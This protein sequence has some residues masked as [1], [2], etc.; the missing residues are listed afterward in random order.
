MVR[1]QI[2]SQTADSSW[3]RK[4]ALQFSYYCQVD[5][6][7][8]RALLPPGQNLPFR[9]AKTIIYSGGMGHGNSKLCGEAF[10][11][12]WPHHRPPGKSLHDPAPVVSVA[13]PT[14]GT[15]FSAIFRNPT[16]RASAATSSSKSPRYPVFR[17]HPPGH[18]LGCVLVW[19]SFLT[20]R[21]HVG[22]IGRKLGRATASRKRK[23]RTQAGQGDGKPA[24]GQSQHLSF[25]SEPSTT[26][27]A[28]QPCSG[29][30]VCMVQR[31]ASAGSCRV[32]SRRG[33]SP[34]AKATSN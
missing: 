28:L 3:Q 25:Q 6:L 2:W 21:S 34:G 24:G 23:S 15:N 17:C 4:G 1:P 26:K 16:R 22:W 18:R 29:L 32:S 11:R 14:R 7:P 19:G 33:S 10:V 30:N 9:A 27:A 31:R 5:L 13:H 12:A 20:R 8:S